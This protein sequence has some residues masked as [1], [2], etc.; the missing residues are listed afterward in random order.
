MI[1]ARWNEINLAERVWT[2]PA[3]R[4]KAA[5]EHRP[6]VGCG[7]LAVIEQ[8]PGDSDFLA[9]PSP[10]RPAMNAGHCSISYAIWAAATFTAHMASAAHSVVTAVG[11]RAHEFPADAELALAHSVVGSKVEAAYRRGD[12]FV[13]RRQM[14]DAWAR[15]C[16]AGPADSGSVKVVAIGAR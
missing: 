7:A 15:F 16:A 6:A 1:G 10:S 12:M 5:R 9:L 11:G 3:N 2:I 4:M 13:K 14:A 8:M